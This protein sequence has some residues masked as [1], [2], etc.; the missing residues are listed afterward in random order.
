SPHRQELRFQLGVRRTLV[1]TRAQHVAMIREIARAR[2]HLVPSC[3]AGYFAPKLKFTNL[4]EATP[5]LIQ[6]LHH[7]I[8]LLDCQIVAVEV[9]LE[10]LA[11]QEPVIR[12]LQTAP[13]VA[14]IVAATFVSVI[15]DAGRFDRAHQVEAYLGLVPSED[16]SGDRRRIG[17]IT[18][19]GNGY[20]RAM[21][22]Q[23]AW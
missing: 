2:G 22:V 8:A 18:K 21:L 3:D 16:S 19:H 23:A 15:D 5:T 13:G 14:A 17:S 4:D 12:L 1:E 11:S 20:A 6:L 10:Q 7:L 9:R